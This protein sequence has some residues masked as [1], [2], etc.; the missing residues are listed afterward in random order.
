MQTHRCRYIID[1]LLRKRLSRGSCR[2]IRRILHGI[3]ILHVP[4]VL[5]LLYHTVDAIHE[6]FMTSF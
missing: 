5:F 1:S 4:C 6:E 2:V 3:S